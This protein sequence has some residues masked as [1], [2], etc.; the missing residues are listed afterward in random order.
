VWR[1]IQAKRKAARYLHAPPLLVEPVP[2][3]A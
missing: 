2:H 3:P 1:D